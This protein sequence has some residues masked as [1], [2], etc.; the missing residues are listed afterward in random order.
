M[1]I[2]AVYLHISNIISNTQSFLWSPPRWGWQSCR[3][4]WEDCP[5]FIIVVFFTVVQLLK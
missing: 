5:K 3:N 1:C 2:L 4:M